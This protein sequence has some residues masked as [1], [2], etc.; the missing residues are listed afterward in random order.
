VFAVFNLSAQPV[1]T[2]FRD[3][4]HFGRYR[5]FSTGDTVLVDGSTRF[6]LA[7]WTYKILTKAE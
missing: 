5:D 6:N 7:P 4:L 2:G 3:D 1:Q